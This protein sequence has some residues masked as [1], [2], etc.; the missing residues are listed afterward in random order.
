MKKISVLKQ[1]KKRNEA[2]IYIFICLL[3]VVKLI[4]YF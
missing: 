3:H 4:D 2:I 1:D